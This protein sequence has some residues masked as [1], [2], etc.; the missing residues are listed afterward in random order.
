MLNRALSNS[1][2]RV[3]SDSIVK[4]WR[5]KDAVLSGVDITNVVTGED[6]TVLIEYIYTSLTICNII[7]CRL[8][9]KGH[10]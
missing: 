6:S 3:L 2:I 8:I 9:V 4:S 5:G 1:K 7:W 10:L